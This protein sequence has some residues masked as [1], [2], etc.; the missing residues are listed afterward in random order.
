MHARILPVVQA[1]SLYF[2][3]IVLPL[4]VLIIHVPLELCLYP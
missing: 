3:N 4:E 2:Q 1:K